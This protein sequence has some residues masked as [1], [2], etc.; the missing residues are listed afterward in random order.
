MIA[1][2]R[3]FSQS[4]ES[5][6]GYPYDPGRTDR[7]LRVVAGVD[8]V[9][10]GATVSRLLAGTTLSHDELN[11]LRFTFE[12]VLAGLS[13]QTSSS[14]DE[15]GLAL[16]GSFVLAEVSV[17]EPWGASSTWFK[18]IFTCAV[19]WRQ[20]LADDEFFECFCSFTERLGAGV[21]K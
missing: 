19:Q 7:M 20:H 11:D 18:Y 15:L 17:R 12:E 4:Y 8:Y 16:L 14:R 10:G 5:V 1:W 13:G 3:L 2:F 9:L 21:G 6:A